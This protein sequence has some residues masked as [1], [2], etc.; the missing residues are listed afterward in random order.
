MAKIY[1]AKTSTGLTVTVKKDAYTWLWNIMYED[2]MKYA[3][4]YKT[5]KEAIEH[6][7]KSEDG[8]G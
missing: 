1:S 3:G 5:R 6:L 7:P 8:E 4:P 2:G